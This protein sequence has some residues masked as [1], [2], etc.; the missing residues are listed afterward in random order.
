MHIIGYFVSHMQSVSDFLY[1]YDPRKRITATQALEHEYVSTFYW[2]S[3]SVIEPLPQM[4]FFI[5][6]SKWFI[7]GFFMLGI[8]DWMTVFPYLGICVPNLFDNGYC[9][10]IFVSFMHSFCFKKRFWTEWWIYAFPVLVTLV[11][12]PIFLMLSWVVWPIICKF[13]A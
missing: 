11:L 10:L 2:L 12:S 4:I 7:C 5:H 8:A 3:S 6:L 9:F 1:R 13:I